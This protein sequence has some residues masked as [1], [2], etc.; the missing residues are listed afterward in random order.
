MIDASVIAKLIMREEDY[1][2]AAKE[3]EADGETLDLAILEVANVILKYHRRGVLSAQ[4]AREKF[5]ELKELSKT[6][7][8]LDFKKFLEQAFELAIMTN[9]TVYDFL[10]IVSSSKL[11]TSDIKQ[12]EAAKQH[13][14]K[15]ILI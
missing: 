13:G 12:A 4:E 11:V 1:V 15:V 5:E 7:R 3:I 14:R 9:L 10:Y 6:L 8:V 2:K